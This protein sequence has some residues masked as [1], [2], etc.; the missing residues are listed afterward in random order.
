MEQRWTLPLT[1]TLTLGAGAW[2]HFALRGAEPLPAADPLRPDF[3][4]RDAHLTEMDRRGEVTRMLEAPEMR[5][6][7]P[8]ELTEA[9]SPVLTLFK[10]GEQWRIASETARVLHPVSEILLDGQVDILRSETKDSAYLHVITRDVRF[11]QETNYAETSAPA[12]IESPGHRVEGVGLQ[13]WLAA[14]VRVKLLDE[15]HG[16]HELN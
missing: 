7:S 9:D 13:A 16:I 6:Y 10:P 4:I 3:I 15:V 11:L 2:I 14:P 1:L 8:R 5:H 12:V